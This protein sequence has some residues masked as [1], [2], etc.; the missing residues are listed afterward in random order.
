MKRTGPLK[1][2]PMKR[3]TRRK[4]VPAFHLRAQRWRSEAACMT[5]SAIPTATPSR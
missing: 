1:R 4:Q 2:K 3:A 5:S